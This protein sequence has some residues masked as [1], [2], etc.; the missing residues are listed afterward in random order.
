MTFETKHR[1]DRQEPERQAV[2]PAL[3][4]VPLVKPQAV[5]LGPAQAAPG[6][7]AFASQRTVQQQVASPVLS[8]LTVQRQ[9]LEA[10]RSERL[11]I[12]RQ[13]GEVQASLPGGAEQA[14]LQRQREQASASIP[15]VFAQRQAQ[16]APTPA[17]FVG[18]YRHEAQALQA[19]TPSGFVP[20]GRWP[21]IQRR[22]VDGLVRSYKALGGPAIQRQADLGI[23]LATLQ[24]QPGGEGLAG[25]VI[26]RL[27]QG[28]RLALQRAM[29]EA[30]ADL[31][32]QEH[33]DAQV[34]HL[35]T[36][37]RQLAEQE[38]QTEQAH[39]MRRVRERQSSGEAL[40]SSVQRQ[41]EAGLNTDL[42]NVRIHTDSEADQLAKG[43]H[44]KA[45]TTGSDIY[46]RR[47]AYQPDS[48]AGL[49]LLAH[50]ATHTVQ[51]ARGRVGAGVDPDA[52][53]EAE[54]RQM[55]AR[56]AGGPVRAKKPK[57]QATTSKTSRGQGR[58]VQRQATPSAPGAQGQR[59]GQPH[60]DPARLAQFRRLVE[61]YQQLL[62]G[63]ELSAAERGRVGA[64]IAR[65]QIAIRAAERTESG[66]SGASSMA[67][68]AMVVAGGLT[69]D[70]V[71]GVGV[72]DDVAIP[73]VLLFAAGAAAVAYFSS[74]SE[75]DKQRAWTA[76]NQ[77]VTAAVGTIE[78]VLAQR[79]GGTQTRDRTEPRVIPR[80]DTDQDRQR[81]NTMR[82]QVQWGTNAGGPTF[83]KVV[84]AP[85][86]IGVTVAQALVA[87]NAVVAEVT[88][89]AAQRAAQPA[90][91]KQITWVQARP[92]GGISQENY[93]KSVYFQ[94]RSFT[95]ARVDVE[96]MRGHNLKT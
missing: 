53:L 5:P 81:M 15:A 21:A 23:Q 32:V 70:D 34:Q 31:A 22:A 18:L 69:A 77:A 47:G 92:P 63:N 8:A 4:P 13:V 59:P 83:S 68:G 26:G 29:N 93:S 39:V 79:R 1:E 56:V 90:L 38:A 19:S 52:G 62:R 14:A 17:D 91:V 2:T 27:P 72:A 80:T 55:G 84:T 61:E 65:A 48:S 25:A 40:P 42:S 50:E 76:A 10:A 75:T 11:A 37:Q 28:E 67:G 57:A 6:L 43:V 88:P 64:A 51:Q 78:G 35:H 58:S 30:D 44:A 20:A 95:D 60:P 71:T 73:F 49:E 74:S 33:Q 12:Q 87:L 82:F 46:F 54:A 66:G 7:S 86:N 85:S 45:F 36:L 41:L 94:Y 24:R 16:Q 96:N 3:Q 9:A 89:S